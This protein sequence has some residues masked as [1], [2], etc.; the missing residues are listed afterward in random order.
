MVLAS[1]LIAV[2]MLAGLVIYAV[3]GVISLARL[4]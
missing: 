1:N 2:A 3:K 4:K